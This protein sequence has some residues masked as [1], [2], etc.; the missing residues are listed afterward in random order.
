MQNFF[1]QLLKE[2]VATVFQTSCFLCGARRYE[3]P[4]CG[5]CLEHALIPIPNPKFMVMKSF[6]AECYYWIT[7]TVLKYLHQAKFGRDPAFFSALTPYL[8]LM[9]NIPPDTWLVPV[10]VHW[11]TLWTRGF[12]QS[13][14]LSKGLASRFGFESRVALEKSVE[15][16]PQA[17]LGRRARLRNLRRC[18]KWIANDTPRCVVLV[19]DVCTTGA[20][21]SAC[22]EAVRRAGVERVYG[23]TFWRTPPLVTARSRFQ[24]KNLEGWRPL[25]CRPADLDPS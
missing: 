14:H 21:L 15:S 8:K 19:D 6:M 1:H 4:V 16:T 18:F 2:V 5:E 13:E 10:P 25:L 9:Q 3:G 20:T 22:I 23:W 12:N 7:P 11:Q 17:F 24:Q